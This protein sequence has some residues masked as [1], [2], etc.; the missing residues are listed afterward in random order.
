M[1][2]NFVPTSALESAYRILP[3]P[4]TVDNILATSGLE[5]SRTSLLDTRE[6]TTTPPATLLRFGTITAPNPIK[7]N[8]SHP[9]PGLLYKV[10]TLTTPSPDVK[11]AIM[12]F[13]TGDTAALWLTT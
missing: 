9:P 2:T 6:E 7:A 3:S 1:C 13:T 8:G 4:R 11:E 12:G 10:G 5:G